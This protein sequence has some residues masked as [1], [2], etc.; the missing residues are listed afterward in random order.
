MTRIAAGHILSNPTY[1]AEVHSVG[2]QF[3]LRIHSQ[4]EFHAAG[5]VQ[6]IRVLEEQMAAFHVLELQRL[7]FVELVVVVRRSTDSYQLNADALVVQTL[8]IQL[9][10]YAEL[11][12]HVQIV[13]IRRR[14]Y[15]RYLNLIP[16]RHDV[17]FPCRNLFG[18]LVVVGEQQVVTFRQFVVE[19][20]VRSK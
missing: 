1:V 16:V 13:E 2:K 5:I 3:I 20:V 8:R 18:N 15:L 6:L 17:L 14:F 9:N 4:T 11:V 7:Y 19:F 10:R 12:T